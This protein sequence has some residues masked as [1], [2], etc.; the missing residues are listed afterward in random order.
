MQQRYKK[1]GSNQSGFEII[2]DLLEKA[3]GVLTLVKCKFNI[4][5]W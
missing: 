1:H 3:C 4:N 5:I 2:G